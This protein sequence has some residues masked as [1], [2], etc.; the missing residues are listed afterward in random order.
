MLFCSFTQLF[1]KTP[2]L[3][4]IGD[5]FNE[6]IT[7]M[8]PQNY[9]IQCVVRD[10]C[11]TES[12]AASLPLHSS[13]VSCLAFSPSSLP[14]WFALMYCIRINAEKEIMP[15][16]GG[17]QMCPKIWSV[18]VWKGLKSKEDPSRDMSWVEWAPRLQNSHPGHFTFLSSEISLIPGPSFWKSDKIFFLV[19][20]RH[21]LRISIR[22]KIE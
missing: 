4:L 17:F 1:Y 15:Y 6:N 13:S 16:P 11:V 9:F 18:C 8:N 14:P 12:A 5:V 3:F 2:R 22:K 19:L 7:C 21:L 10:S 20:F